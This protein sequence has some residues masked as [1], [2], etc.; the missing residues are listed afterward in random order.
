M[1][2]LPPYMQ[3]PKIKLFRVT[4]S[5]DTNNADDIENRSTDAYQ[6]HSNPVV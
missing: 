6:K 3:Y 1:E 5:V 2:D 4:T